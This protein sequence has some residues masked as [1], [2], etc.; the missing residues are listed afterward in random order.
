MG[1]DPTSFS[2]ADQAKTVE[3]NINWT[4]DFTKKTLRGFVD[5]KVEILQE[6]TSEVVSFRCRTVGPDYDMV[7]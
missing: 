2:N 5:L 1:G 3:I 4:V 6:S 7:V